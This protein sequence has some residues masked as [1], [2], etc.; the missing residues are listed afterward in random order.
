MP[1]LASSSARS[2]FFTVL[3]DRDRDRDRD[4]DRNREREREREWDRLSLSLSR[5][6]CPKGSS[7][8]LSVVPFPSS[9]DMM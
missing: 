7:F 2:V 9:S 3:R 6:R 8:T 1:F 4:G 5:G